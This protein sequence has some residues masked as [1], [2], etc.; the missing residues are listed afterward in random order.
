ME[1]NHGIGAALALL[2]ALSVSAQS[3]GSTAG[4][5]PA[6]PAGAVFNIVDWDGGPLPPLY[7]R[8]AQLPLSLD[9]VIQLSEAEFGD[10]AIIKMLQERRC[11]CDASVPSLI[12]LKQSGVSE[13][14]IQAMSLHALAPNRHL[15]LVIHMDFEGLGG[16]GAVSTQARKSYL[17]LIIPDGDRDRVF[18]GNLQRALGRTAATRTLVDN[19]DLLLPKPVRRASFMARVPLK[20]HGSKRAL[21]FLSTRPD[22]YTVADIPAADRKAAQEFTFDYPAS[23]LQSRCSLQVLHRQDVM[24]ADRWNLERSHFECEWD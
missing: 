20:V 17:Y 12:R 24:L 13:T 22:I 8:S 15:D 5:T 21:V 6:L 14:V 1:R 19:T 18:F 2:V 16:A 7:E 3:T 11:A 4:G 23:S 10:E 9:D